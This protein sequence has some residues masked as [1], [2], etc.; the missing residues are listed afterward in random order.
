MNNLI[1][2][3]GCSD[4]PPCWQLKDEVEHERMHNLLID[5]CEQLQD[6]IFSKE[7][8]EQE[9]CLT[10]DA[11]I[12]TTSQLKSTNENLQKLRTAAR[13]EARSKHQLILT[14]WNRLNETQQ[15]ENK[16]TSKKRKY[17]DFLRG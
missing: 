16:R 17:D 11:L 6:T 9:L 1:S 13:T 2:R 7:L 3:E 12:E 5:Q 14:L 15:V 4:R 8:I 10:K